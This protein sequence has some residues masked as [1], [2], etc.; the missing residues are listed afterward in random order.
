MTWAC[1][2]AGRGGSAGATPSF[3][4]GVLVC[5]TSA[6]A[7]V[8]VDLATR[9]LLWGFLYLKPEANRQIGGF[10][11]RPTSRRK[12]A[13]VGQAWADS[14]VTI[15]DGKVLVTPV[16]ADEIHCLDLLNGHVHWK[17]DRGDDLFVAAIHEGTGVLVGRRHVTALEMETGDPLWTAELPA[18]GMPSG[19]GFRTQG[20][21]V[22]PTTASE[23][24]KINLADG[25]VLERIPSQDVLGNLVAYKDAVISQGVSEI[26]SFY[27]LESLR[28]AVPQRL[29]KNPADAEALAQQGM[30]LL[31]E[32]KQ[33]EA[34]A[35]LRRS[36]ELDPRS[37]AAKTETKALLIET[38]LAALREDFAANRQLAAEVEALIDG[39]RE[40]EEFLRL[41]AVGLMRVGEHS[42]A[43]DFYL[44]IADEANSAQSG[45]VS[46]RDGLE[47]VDG[48][49]HARRDRWY[50][51]RLREFLTVVD[52]SQREAAD[53]AIQQRLSAVLKKKLD[54][55][56]AAI[57]QLFRSASGGRR[58]AAGIGHTVGRGWGIARGG[59]DLGRTGRK[60]HSGNCRPGHG[61]TR[62]PAAPLRRSGPRG[63]I[64]LSTQGPVR[65]RRLWRWQDGPP[66][67]ECLAGGQR[68]TGAL[69]GRHFLAL[70]EGRGE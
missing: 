2:I 5:P 42:L 6:G 39:A 69:A 21:Y 14:T 41:M 11:Q 46:P 50:A 31:H 66:M 51:A 26:Q 28:R 52:A 64:F 13:E 1:W 67:V 17:R 27:Q 60:K 8:A 62:P 35:V 9:S 53:R 16:E 58:R 54:R 25:Q 63:A 30:L 29:A 68:R 49:L 44:K 47:Q 38:L 45:M 33:S 57:R 23:I 34:L 65:R 19:R 24:V 55:R 70:W 36:F 22:L 15:A 59:I 61:A 43:W 18:G 32:G 3:A 12:P 20:Q 37:E 40:R 4:D 56:P 10:F 7:V 48:V